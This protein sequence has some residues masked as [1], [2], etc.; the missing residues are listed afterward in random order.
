MMCLLPKLYCMTLLNS[1]FYIKQ[2]RKELNHQRS[3]CQ[4]QCV[5]KNG[6]NTLNKGGDYLSQNMK[7]IKIF[8]F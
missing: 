7:I 4:I 8:V 2:E 3:K 6:S 1:T 5:K